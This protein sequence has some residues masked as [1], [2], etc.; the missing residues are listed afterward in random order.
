MEYIKHKVKIIEIY[1]YEIEVEANS[2]KEVLEKA[3]KYYSTTEDGY[4]GVA[5][6]NTLK[7]T[8]FKLL[9]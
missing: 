1:E 7:E 8:K 5:N 4:I 2:K 3:K 6:A 9:K